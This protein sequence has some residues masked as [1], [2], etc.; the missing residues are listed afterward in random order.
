MA[1][2]RWELWGP[3]SL[4]T[5]Q[6]HGGTLT[7][8]GKIDGNLDQNGLLTVDL[9]AKGKPSKITVTGDYDAHLGTIKESINGSA[10]AGIDYG[11]LVVNKNATLSGEA[12]DT[13]GA[14]AAGLNVGDPLLDVI[15][16]VQIPRAVP[17]TN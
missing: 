10:Q 3:W 4:G 17:S 9:S 6:F 13:T 15:T 11:Q 16:Y 12:M 14:N 1:L 5:F 2:L 7:G 8:V